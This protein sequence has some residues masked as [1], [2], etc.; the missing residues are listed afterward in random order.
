MRRITLLAG[1]ALLSSA[2]TA[3]AHGS[4]AIM[5]Y[6]V[7]GLPPQVIEDREAQISLIAPLLEDFHTPGGDIDGIDSIVALQEAFYAP[8]Y[9]TLTDDQTVSYPFI[10][11][12][13]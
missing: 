3:F 11:P 10:T 9:E 13:S 1:V 8:Y 4:F 5:T 7:R 2:S 12:K 6:N